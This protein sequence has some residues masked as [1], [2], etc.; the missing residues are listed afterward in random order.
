M[1]VRLGRRAPH[2]GAV[3]VAVQP[4]WLRT[5]P[6]HKLAGQLFGTIGPISCD[7]PPGARLTA[8][9][10]ELKDPRFKGVVLITSSMR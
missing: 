7:A 6:L 2:A 4:V 9:N 10:C 3:R 1:R 5:Y 8:S